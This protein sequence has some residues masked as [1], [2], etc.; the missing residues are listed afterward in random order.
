MTLIRRGFVGNNI[1][2]GC[3][4]SG[5][6]VLSI[7]LLMRGFARKVLL[8]DVKAVL[9]VFVALLKYISLCLEIDRI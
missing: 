6:E 7:S 5:E 3:F 9:L 1:V 4:I 8:E 2:R